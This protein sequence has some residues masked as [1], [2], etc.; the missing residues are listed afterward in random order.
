MPHARVHS[1]IIFADPRCE[2]YKVSAYFYYVLKTYMAKDKFKKEH[3]G[4]KIIKVID[5]GVSEVEF[6]W[7]K[8][9]ELYQET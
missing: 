7:S 3:P 9:N 2:K 8:Y 5:L 4:C 1:V 6:A